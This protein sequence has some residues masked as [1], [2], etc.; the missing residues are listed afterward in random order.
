[1]GHWDTGTLDTGSA[2]AVNRLSSRSKPREFQHLEYRQVFNT[3]RL[4]RSRLGAGLIV[5]ACT[6]G[7]TAMGV[8]RVDLLQEHVL[9]N[10]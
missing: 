3:S 4:L 10:P 1:M 6:S 8:L 5:C 7:L 2:Y 9:H